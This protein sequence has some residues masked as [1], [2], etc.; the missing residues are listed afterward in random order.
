MSDERP[1]ALKKR[2]YSLDDGGI[3]RRCIIHYHRNTTD[4]EVR[5]LTLNSFATIGITVAVR[6]RQDSASYRLAIRVASAITFF[7][8]LSNVE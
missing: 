5:P 4:V 8:L 7:G 2:R 6:Q 3:V 1:I